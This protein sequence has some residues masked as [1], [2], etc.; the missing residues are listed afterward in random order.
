MRAVLVILFGL[1]AAFGPSSVRAFD[2]GDLARVAKTSRCY[3]CDLLGADFRKRKLYHANL[4]DSDLRLAQF[5]GAKLDGARFIESDLRGASFRG[6]SMRFANL[7]SANLYGVDFRGADLVATRLNGTNLRAADLTDANL[8]AGEL[9]R[10]DVSGADFTRT[11]L[12]GTNLVGVIGLTQ[13]QLDG[14]CGDK[15]TKLPRGLAIN[16]CTVGRNFRAPLPFGK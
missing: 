7:R 4:G 16:R 2:P 9:I 15:T 3:G 13:A 14:A 11:R 12:Y 1:A 5:V 8:G 6:V 10:A